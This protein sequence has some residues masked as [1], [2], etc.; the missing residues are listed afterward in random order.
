[1]PDINHVQINT[2]RIPVGSS[3]GAAALIAIVLLGMFLDLPGVRWT[4]L[5]GGT[6]GLVFAA[7]LIWR[8][9][10]HAGDPP[11]PTLGVSAR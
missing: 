8:R 3:M 1:M 7:G 2:Q 4:A 5:G 6:V 9:R 10:R 11:H